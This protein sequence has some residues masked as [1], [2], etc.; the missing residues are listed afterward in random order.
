MHFSFQARIIFALNLLQ[1]K[2]PKL[3]RVLAFFECKSVKCWFHL[4][5]KTAMKM[6]KLLPLKMCPFSISNLKG[7][8]NSTLLTWSLNMLNIIDCLCRRRFCRSCRRSLPRCFLC[9]MTSW[10]CRCRRRLRCRGGALWR[11]SWVGAVYIWHEPVKIK[12]IAMSI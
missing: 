5:N 1:S 11:F 4:R 9:R 7:S 6:V 3:F 10:R 8:Y 12:V 2:G